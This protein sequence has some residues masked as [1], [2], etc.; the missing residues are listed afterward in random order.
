M[1]SQTSLWAVAD[2]LADGCPPAALGL[3]VGLGKCPIAGSNSLTRRVVNFSANAVSRAVTHGWLKGQ[4]FHSQEGLE[5]REELW[6]FPSKT[7]R[8]S[9][10]ALPLDNDLK[11]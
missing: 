6:K 4:L 8:N 9:K 11:S 2:L 7:D 5:L 1:T 3:L 10:W